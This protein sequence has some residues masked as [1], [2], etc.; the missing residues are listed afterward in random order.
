[1]SRIAYSMSLCSVPLLQAF[2]VFSNVTSVS[3]TQSMSRKTMLCIVWDLGQI[4]EA[5][6]IPAFKDAHLQN[7]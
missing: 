5:F 3:L 6:I 1:M 4:L 7:Y 2:M